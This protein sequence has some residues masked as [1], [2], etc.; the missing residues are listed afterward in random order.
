MP[1]VIKSCPK[2]SAKL[3]ITDRHQGKSIQCPGCGIKLKVP[4]VSSTSDPGS[5]RSPHSS[6]ETPPT[7]SVTP[8]GT[9]AD[10]GTGLF[11]NLDLPEG[12]SDPA[13]SGSL[14]ADAAV[15]FAGT[16]PTRLH[17]APASQKKPK[18]RRN[19][20]IPPR[21]HGPSRRF[22]LEAPLAR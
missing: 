8:G 17:S 11:E 4:G 15:P 14:K 2:C 20:P 7:S 3:K 9:P 10:S 19:L 22:S 18:R 5:S 1:T 13:F 16:R 12:V 6:L 21:V